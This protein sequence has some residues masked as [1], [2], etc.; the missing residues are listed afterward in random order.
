MKGAL[1]EGFGLPVAIEQEGEGA[2]GV[3]AVVVGLRSCMPCHAGRS[4]KGGQGQWGEAE[5]QR[6]T[7]TRAPTPPFSS[8]LIP[9]S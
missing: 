5:S 9:L 7:I 6:P 1:E 2:A 3:V 8:E 4:C